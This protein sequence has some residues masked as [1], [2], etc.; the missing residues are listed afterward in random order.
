ML[1]ALRY[2]ASHMHTP[3]G[4][5]VLHKALADDEALLVGASFRLGELVGHL[6]NHVQV[7][8]PI[9]YRV[10]AA[11]CLSRTSG[12]ISQMKKEHKN[13]VNPVP[14]IARYSASSVLR[15]EPV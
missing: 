1:S 4:D 14:L 8:N 12:R 13:E 7:H 9:W 2:C 11:P 10:R 3:Q 6:R 15:R 5:Y